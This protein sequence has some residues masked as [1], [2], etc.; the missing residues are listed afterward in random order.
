MRW[1]IGWGIRKFLTGNVGFARSV[2]TKLL[3][4]DGDNLMIPTSGG[5]P[6]QVR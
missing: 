1:P 5:W 6:G 3:P 2:A 4:F